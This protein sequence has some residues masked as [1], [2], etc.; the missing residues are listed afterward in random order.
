MDQK[1]S[2]NTPST[3]SLSMRT[4]IKWIAIGD[5]FFGVAVMLVGYYKFDAG[6][7]QWF[8]SIVALIGGLLFVTIRLLERRD[9]R[10]I[11]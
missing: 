10:K 8:G 6:V 1:D 9:A 11:N 7:V 5:V 2:D 4:M 3:R